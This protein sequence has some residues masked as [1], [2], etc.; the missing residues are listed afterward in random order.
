MEENMVLSVHTGDRLQEQINNAIHMLKDDIFYLDETRDDF[1]RLEKTAEEAFKALRQT[2]KSMIAI[3]NIAMNVKI[4]GFN[5]SI[6]ANRVKENGKGF[7]VIASEVRNLAET[8]NASVVKISEAVMK[9]DDFRDNLSS[10]IEE[11]TKRY[12][13]L[14]DDM[15]KVIDTLKTAKK[16]I[17]E[18]E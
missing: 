9:L 17:P 6:E 16:D 12:G 8:T 4:L 13:Y 10:G 5:A 1:E 3:Q 7:S 15:K 14:Y 2:E 18:Q 11:I